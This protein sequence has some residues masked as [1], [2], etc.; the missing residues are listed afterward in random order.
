MLLFFWKTWASFHIFIP[1]EIYINHWWQVTITTGSQCSLHLQFVSEQQTQSLLD[2][3]KCIWELKRHKRSDFWH[4]TSVALTAT[5]LL[6]YMHPM[7][8]RR[9]V[10]QIYWKINSAAKSHN[11]VKLLIM[12]SRH[13]LYF[14]THLF[15]FP[16]ERR[17]R[18]QSQH[19]QIRKKAQSH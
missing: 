16:P 1:F 5:V 8:H 13:D 15:A 19:G 14:I 11:T 17:Q 6:A 10:L 7:T 9:S 3:K 12:Y 18:V 2:W 4:M